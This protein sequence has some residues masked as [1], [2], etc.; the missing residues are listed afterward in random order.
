MKDYR[1]LFKKYVLRKYPAYEP[2]VRRELSRIRGDLF[3]DIGANV[4][5]YTVRLAS[6]FRSVYAFEPNPNVLPELRWRIRRSRRNNIVV[7]PM[8]LANANGKAEFYLDAQRTFSMPTDI[9]L[10]LFRF[11]PGRDQNAGLT[12]THHGRKKITVPTAAYDSQ[13]PE[14][15]DLVKIDVEGA[16]FLVLEGAKKA[17]ESGRIRRLM[18]ELHDLE[19]QGELEDLLTGYGFNLRKL[20]PNSSRIIAYARN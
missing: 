5:I 15:A 17:L 14:S 13:V 11:E 8:A 1:F 19:R 16:E 20:D 7:F 9:L 18:I 6:H 4:G 10:R 3:V 2:Q 12:K